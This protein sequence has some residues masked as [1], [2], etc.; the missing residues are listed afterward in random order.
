MGSEYQ[1]PGVPVTELLHTDKQVTELFSPRI[2]V[3]Q[4]KA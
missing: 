2:S 1:H 3:K 4:L